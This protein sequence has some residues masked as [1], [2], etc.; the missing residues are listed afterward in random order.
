MT[1]SKNKEKIKNII[2]ALFFFVLAILPVQVLA[3]LQNIEDV[4]KPGTMYTY[5]LD[6]QGKYEKITVD[7]SKKKNYGETRVTVNGQEIYRKVEKKGEQTRVMVTDADKNDKQ[8]EL[9]ILDGED[10]EHIY[11]YRY[12]NGITRRV[13]DLTPL[14]RGGD[15][16]GASIHG[17]SNHIPLQTNGKGV[18]YA[19]VQGYVAKEKTEDPG[20]KVG[21]LLAN[22]KFQF[23][24]RTD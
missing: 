12:E 20:A 3:S 18:L 8:M 10:M 21:L 19:R 9:L 22:G 17:M 24:Q 2:L 6:K 5:N 11:Y 23:P 7:Y 16:K 14:Y 4:L 1:E 13:Q 15:R